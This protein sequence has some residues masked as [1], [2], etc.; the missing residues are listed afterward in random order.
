M[1]RFEIEKLGLS[2]RSC[3][4][5]IKAGVYTVDELIG[6]TQ[7]DLLTIQNLGAKSVNEITAMIQKLNT[8]ALDI[9]DFRNGTNMPIGEDDYLVAHAHQ[10]KGLKPDNVS[11]IKNGMLTDDLSLEEAGLRTRAGNALRHHN[12]FTLSAVCHLTYGQL[13]S[14]QNLGQKSENEIIDSIRKFTIPDDSDTAQK[15]DAL[16]RAADAILPAFVNDVFRDALGK[17]KVNTVRVLRENASVLQDEA[18]PEQQKK[19]LAD[20]LMQDRFFT[21]LFCSCVCAYIDS[22]DR[23]TAEEL[24]P[25]FADG[26]VTYRDSILQMLV[27]EKVLQ[28]T[29]GAYE[30]VYP[31]FDAYLATLDQTDKALRYLY[32]KAH[33]KT[34]EEIGSEDGITRERVR[35]VIVKALRKMPKVMEDK[36]L[37]LFEKYDLNREKVTEAL[38]FSDTVYEY[39]SMRV[40][41]H[42]R[43]DYV[44]ML[45]EDIPLFLKKSIEAY[46][47]RNYLEVDGT[48]I[49]KSRNAIL[50]YILKTKCT[51]GVT[52]QEIGDYYTA[53]LQEHGLDSEKF[54]YPQRYFETRLADQK[55]VLWRLGGRLRYY[56]IDDDDFLDLLQKI[57]FDSYQNVELSTWY[58][59]IHYPEVMK[60]YDL[61]DEYELHN[62]LS[63]RT[64]LL[65]R[66]D[67]KF[68]R[69]PNIG[70]GAYDRDMQV[71]NM[72][73]EN[74]PISSTELS[75]LYET[76]YGMKN[77]AAVYF[78]CISDY[79]DR[80]VYSID[81]EELTPEERSALTEIL[82]RDI[83]ELD[84]VKRC[85]SERFPGG[86]T[87]KI[88][89]YNLRKLGY[90]ICC[91][92]VYS[93]RCGSFEHLLKNTLLCQDEIDLRQER[94]LYQ[95]QT[96][97]VL[98]WECRD[99][100]EWIEFLPKQYIRASKLEK[101]GATRE[102]L[103]DFAKKAADFAQGNYFTIFSLKKQGFQHELF[104]LPFETY[105]YESVLRY[106]QRVKSF[107]VGIGSTYV[108]RET[109]CS[110]MR[111]M[112]EDLIGEIG[113]IGVCELLEYLESVYGIKLEKYKLTAWAKDS[114]LYY[115]ESLEK[116]FKDYQAFCKEI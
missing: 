31:T 48:R 35:Q 14:F 116:I 20:L 19:Q 8:G 68:N 115:S 90:K 108:F 40:R 44:G 75:K 11:F 33:G 107:Y 93:T 26:F 36:Y 92:L 74:A 64:H 59:F 85:F 79:L 61:R 100:Q 105:F 22:Q 114:R 13:M 42:G 18:T 87:D 76:K 89:N 113:S 23:A 109:E 103:T 45:D 37:W 112:L 3:N 56:T 96:V 27:D 50:Y 65:G 60:A 34:L 43:A 10:I 17:I 62:L 7:N 78:V 2:A 82:S 21:S 29:D 77:G 67:V 69:M 83:L 70:F 55:Y 6:L 102:L 12:C 57:D 5:L 58:F 88:C 72:L 28:C 97:N 16:N 30:R 15:K 49:E 51:N 80:G 1:K 25:I 24:S 63:K 110:G 46:R 71:L 4:G 94:A 99:A 106:S 41:K 53:F 73:I 81:Y 47:Y 39:Y 38:G 104:A 95:N 91:N 9:M 66:T 54:T 52:K 111:K 98:L 84:E 101:M 32:L 86:N